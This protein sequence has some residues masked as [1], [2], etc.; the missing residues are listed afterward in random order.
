MLTMCE[1]V[2]Q[3]G[4][5]FERRIEAIGKCREL[6][7]DHPGEREEVKD[8]KPALWLFYCYISGAVVVEQRS[9]GGATR[10]FRL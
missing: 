4:T 10:G 2:Q 6:V 5:H 1:A 9:E 8:P 7:G 3:L